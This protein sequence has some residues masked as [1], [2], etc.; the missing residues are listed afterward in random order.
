MPSRAALI[1]RHAR[2]S[3]W[4]RLPRRSA[5]DGA[6]KPAHYLPVYERLAAPLRFRRCAILEL[7][8][9]KGDS[10]VM[11]RDGLP[12]AT[13]VGID[14]DPPHVDLGPRVHLV[15]GDQSDPAALAEA[16]RLAPGGFDLIVDDG[17]HQ[18]VVAARSLQELFVAQLKPGGAYVVEDWGTG[19][20]AG[21]ADGAR[22]VPVRAG[23]LDEHEAARLPSHDAGMV[24]L[25]KRL[26][27]H[28]GA[29]RT[30]ER[31][32]YPEA[33]D[34]DPLPIESIEIRQGL[35]VLRKLG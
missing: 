15:A 18:G 8:I 30:L 29:R 27:D 35:A 2:R 21:W 10:L 19:Y 20:M 13:V 28:I 23:A 9:W 25:L 1:R 31:H 26:V 7:G 14:L 6:V 11:W 5:P 4:L 32:G 22:P 12:R 17:A 34:H 33:A 16:R 3:G 24:G